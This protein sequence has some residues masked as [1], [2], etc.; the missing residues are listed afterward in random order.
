[1]ATIFKPLMSLIIR[2][3]ETKTAFDAATFESHRGLSQQRHS[4]ARHINRR[5]S[6]NCRFQLEMFYPYWETSLSKLWALQFIL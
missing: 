5:A 4:Q 6:Q 3:R 1:M 2:E